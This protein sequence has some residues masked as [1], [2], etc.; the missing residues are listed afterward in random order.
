MEQQDQRNFILFLVI[1]VVFMLGYQTFIVEPQVAQREAAEQQ[2]KVEQAEAERIAP[3]VPLAETLEA[4]LA[5]DTRL[6]F[7]SPSLDGTIRL[8]GA[9]IDDLN[10]K[11]YYQTISRDEEVRLLRPEASEFGYYGG[12]NWLTE[13]GTPL[14]GFEDDWTLVSGDRLTPTS[15]VTLQIEIGGVRISRQISLDEN[16]MFTM[17]DTLTNLGTG[18]RRLRAYGAIRRHGDDRDFLEVTTPGANR[19]RGLVH[20]GIVGIL[21][22]KLEK[23]N[24]KKIKKGEDISAASD[25][26]G[27]IGL[28]DK[29]WLGALIPQQDQRFTAKTEF[30][31]RVADAY[32]EVRTVGTELTVPPGA[33]ITA[34]NQL[35]AGAKSVNVLRDYE[36][37]LGIDRFDDAVDWGLLYFLTKPFFTALSWLAAKLGSFGLGILAFVVIIKVILFPLYNK[38]YAA[39]AQMK[40][41]Q[42]PM[43]DIQERFAADPQ[44][45]QQEIMKL[46]KEKKANPLAG[47]LPILFTIP[48]FFALYKVLF[49]TIEMRHDSFAWLTDL[50]AP[51]PTAI[52]NL[53]GLL[54]F[55]AES[56]KSIPLLGFIIGIGIL[57]ILYGV[58]MFIL[59]NISTPP[60]D[61]MQRRIIMMLPLIFTFVFGGLASGLV[62]YWVWNNV[63]SIG[64]QYYIMRKNGV[65]TQVD[66]FIAKRFGKAEGGGEA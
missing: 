46:Y 66:K 33:S 41:L 63:L 57:P 10:L 1:A 17:E 5:Q 56:V 44:R 11:Q 35:F 6:V 45:K 58:T 62:L 43:K 27:W 49:V 26:G 25:E 53:F 38:S 12:W 32:T 30:R 3:S 64:Q 16:F 21:N 39:M 37:T 59:Q 50:S 24:F 22:G 54:P 8:R 48:V 23:L 29:Y 40:L 47:C 19:D 2:A 18:Q 20:L 61:P 51:D 52:G 7:D 31:T 13:E 14:T 4:A 36:A 42:E 34:T 9:V 55:A 28:T 65:E 60:A 15:P